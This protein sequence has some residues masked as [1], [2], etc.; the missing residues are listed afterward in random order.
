MGARDLL[1]RQWSGYGTFHQ[2]RV[3]LILHVVTVP[4]FM[5]ATVLLAV[6]VLRLSPWLA[7]AA[8]AGL[9]LPILVQGKGHAL[10]DRKAIPFTGAGN[11][12][13]R[14]FL[15]QWVTFPRFVL[16]GGW[17]RTYAGS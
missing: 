6:A 16:S 8:L 2:N 9:V 1:E 7:A 15:E 5:A 4:V 14:L 11:A 12:V 17:A 3:N 10:E 13:A